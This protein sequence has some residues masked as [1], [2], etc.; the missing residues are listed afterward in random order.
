M[1]RLCYVLDLNGLT[2]KVIALSEIWITGRGYMYMGYAG[3]GYHLRVS[4]VVC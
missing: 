1:K 4:N 2:L 3:E